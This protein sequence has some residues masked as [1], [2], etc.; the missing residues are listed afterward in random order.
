MKKFMFLREGG[1][2][3]HLIIISISIIVGEHMKTLSFKFNQ[4]QEIHEEFDF[5]GGNIFS[6]GPKGRRVVRFKKIKK[7]LYRTVVSSQSQIFSI[8]AELESV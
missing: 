7:S 2:G 4:N 5:W 6:G 1:G 8:P 3:G